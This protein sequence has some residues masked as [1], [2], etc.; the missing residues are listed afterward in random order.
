MIDIH[1]HILPEIDDGPR[2][3]EESLALC[4]LFIQE[5]V[6]TVVATPHIFDVRYPNPNSEQILDALTHLRERLSGRL[7]IVCGAEVRLV[8]EVTTILGR[9]ELFINHGPYLLVEL[10]SKIIPHGIEHLIFSLTSSGIKPIIA[11]PERN[12][13]FLEHEER[14]RQLLGMGCS[15]HLDAPALLNEK[16]PVF[17]TALRWIKAGLIHCVA[18]D[19]HRPDWRPPQLAAAR[20]RVKQE[21]GDRVAQALFVENPQ[22]IL[23]GDE[24]PPILPL[25]AEKESLLGWM[26]KRL[27]FS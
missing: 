17:K 4:E 26:Q 19:A 13:V 1:N 9:K 12:L 24:L 18:S 27:R 22:A 14:L 8:P 11:H 23:R 21:Y 16:T 7:Q 5:G 10:P 25:A 2:T 3:W 15:A 6:T 20:A